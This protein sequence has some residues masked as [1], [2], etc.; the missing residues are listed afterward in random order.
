MSF[1]CRRRYQDEFEGHQ[2]LKVN[3]QGPRRN[4]RCQGRLSKVTGAEVLKEAE[5]EDLRVINTTRVRAKVIAT[6]GP[7][8]REYAPANKKIPFCYVV[9]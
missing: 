4:L 8:G 9:K 1:C 2:R 6:E 3:P 7:Q 5:G